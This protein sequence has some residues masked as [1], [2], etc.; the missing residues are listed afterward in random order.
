MRARDSV[1][2]EYPRSP[3]HR[4][5]FA[6]ITA[7]AWTAFAWLVLPA[8]TAVLWLVG[9]SVAYDEAMSRIR[10]IDVTL[11]LG[12][13]AAA[14]LGATLLVGWAEIQ[15]RRF[16][17]VERR[18]RT[19]DVDIALVGA[20]LGATP[21]VTGQLQAGRVMVLHM[22]ADGTPLDVVEQATVRRP[23]S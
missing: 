17:G 4:G 5:F 7:A 23:V 3:L 15:R 14:A 10:E 1:I 9:L 16:A 20:A 8:I 6:L 12:I 22:R 19:P 21:E 2:T 18:A 13:I 11:L